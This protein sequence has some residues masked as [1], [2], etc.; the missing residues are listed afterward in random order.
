VG[1]EG[2]TKDEALEEDDEDEEEEG[3]G[4]DG[5]QVFI[6]IPPPLDRLATASLWRHA[7]LLAR[8]SS[9]N[10]SCGIHVGVRDS[11]SALD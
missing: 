3:E 5:G 6:F 10:T 4:K 8:G 11:V 7:S 1:S 2:L 9:L